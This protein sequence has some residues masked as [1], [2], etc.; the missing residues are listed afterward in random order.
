MTKPALVEQA[1]RGAQPVSLVT[2]SQQLNRIQSIARLTETAI[3]QTSAVHQHAIDAARRTLSEAGRIQR[4]AGQSV[5]D[6]EFRAATNAYLDRLTYITE[7][8]GID[9][10][11][12]IEGTNR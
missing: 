1:L 3:A 6:P 7:A 10:L 4:S 8:A 9:M 12:V 5:D 11:R 2:S